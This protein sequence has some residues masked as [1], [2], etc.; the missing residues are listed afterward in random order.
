MKTIVAIAIAA[1]LASCGIEPIA[2]VE[3]EGTQ[4]A[5]VSAN[6]ASGTEPRTTLDA[7]AAQDEE[8]EV[9]SPEEMARLALIEKG[10]AIY[11]ESCNDCHPSA[12]LASDDRL[13]NKTADEISAGLLLSFHPIDLQTGDIDTEALAAA[14]DPDAV[15]DASDDAEA[16]DK[17]KKGKKGKKGKDKNK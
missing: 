5:K 2:P 10:L 3:E 4:R 6:T 17:D 13:E 9:L 12:D 1:M 11:N 14:A 15:A 8:Q 7:S 16:D